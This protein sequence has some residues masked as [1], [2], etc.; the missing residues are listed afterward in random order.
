MN[1]P[2]VSDRARTLERFILDS[3]PPARAMQLRVLEHEA[4]RLLMGAPLAANIN[5]KGCAFGGSLTS[6]MTLAGWSLVELLLREHGHDC[7]VFVADSQVRYLKPVW[8]DLRAEAR[9]AADADAG[10]FLATLAARGKA[11]TEV[12]CRI[13]TAEGE[14]ATLQARFVARTRSDTAHAAQ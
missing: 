1:T 7:D 9:F 5:D 3:I 12:R 14:A 6:L 13:L 4:D 10:A 2:T 11:R 8:E